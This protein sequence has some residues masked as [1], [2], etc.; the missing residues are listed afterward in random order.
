MATSNL[1]PYLSDNGPV[2]LEFPVGVAYDRDIASLLS[3]EVAMANLVAMS[4]KSSGGWSETDARIRRNRQEKEFS[5]GLSLNGVVLYENEF[6]GIAGF[7]DINSWNKSAEMGIILD[8]KFWH[9]GIS[10]RAH[11][12]CLE[13]AYEIA[14]INRVEFKTASSNTAMRKFCIDTLQATHEGTLRDYFPTGTIE[15]TYENVELY[16]ILAAEWPALR[17]RLEEKIGLI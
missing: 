16:S 13:Y 6:A 14:G 4:K 8:P 17:R 10:T 7:R 12:L 1:P 9:K 5:E 15:N 3:N 2:R 11:F